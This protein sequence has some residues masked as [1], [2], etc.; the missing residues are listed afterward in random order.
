MPKV[1]LSRN[2][3]TQREVSKKPITEA[4]SG[5]GRLQT[6]LEV[7]LMVVWF[8]MGEFWAGPR[9]DILGSLELLSF[10]KNLS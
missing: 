10:P 2:L 5:E 3:A 6:W 4:P 7:H 9:G 8:L 1:W